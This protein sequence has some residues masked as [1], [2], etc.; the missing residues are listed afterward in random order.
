MFFFTL[1]SM[2]KRTRR[3]ESEDLVSLILK[4]I[5]LLLCSCKLTC[6]DY[7]A[8]LYTN[9]FT[10]GEKKFYKYSKQNYE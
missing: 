7:S 10:D 2:K 1:K 5:E 4:L 8:L 6:T 9:N 3:V